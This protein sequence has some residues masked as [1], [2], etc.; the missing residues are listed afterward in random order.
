M[1]SRPSATPSLPA[2]AFASTAARLRALRSL[3]LFNPTALV[4][5]LLERSGHP[6]A[7]T[8]EPHLQSAID[9]IVAAQDATPDDGIARGYSVAYNPYFGSAGWQASYPETTGYIIP[10]LLEAAVHFG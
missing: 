10:T 6:V 2:R 8:H 4:E 1:E 3:P 5:L 9:W 7:P